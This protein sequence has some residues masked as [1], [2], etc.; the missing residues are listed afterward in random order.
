MRLFCIFSAAIALAVFALLHAAEATVICTP[1][2]G[3]TV[4]VTCGP[5]D[6][7]PAPKITHVVKRKHVWKS[8][9]VRKN[10]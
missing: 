6:S 1:K 10:Q 5:D 4:M 3:I 9:H 7:A 2:D 8:K